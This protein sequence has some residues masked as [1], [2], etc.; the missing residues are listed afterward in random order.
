MLLCTACFF[1]MCLVSKLA[2][3]FAEALHMMRVL[4]DLCLP[5]LVQMC[6]DHFHYFRFLDANAWPRQSVGSEGTRC[7]YGVIEQRETQTHIHL[8]ESNRCLMLFHQQQQPLFTG[9]L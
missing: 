2:G 1:W 9:I 8:V 7:S 3:S 6:F 5:D 4:C